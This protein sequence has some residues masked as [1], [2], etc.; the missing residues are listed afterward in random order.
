MSNRGPIDYTSISSA[1]TF[2]PPILWIMVISTGSGGL[3]VK[4]ETGTSRTYAG[5]AAG[6]P[7]L[8]GPFTEITSMTCTKIRVGDSLPVPTPEKG[9]SGLN[10]AS[11]ADLSSMTTGQVIR[12]TGTDTLGAGAVNLANTAAVT[13]SLPATNQQTWATAAA[14]TG[15]WTVAIDTLNIHNTT[16]TAGVATLPAISASND[17]RRSSPRRAAI[18]WAA[19]RRATR[20]RRDRRRA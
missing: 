4:D 1:V 15:S 12:A 18:P 17:G 13:G 7:P 14:E 6:D 9:S 20:P 8:V 19:P 3:V 11:V 5:L 10:G 2:V 16:N